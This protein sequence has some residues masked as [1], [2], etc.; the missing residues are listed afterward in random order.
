MLLLIL[1]AGVA[2]K[3]CTLPNPFAFFLFA[4][5]LFR[6]GGFNIGKN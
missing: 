6:R 4:R 5:V 3:A 1:V 2:A